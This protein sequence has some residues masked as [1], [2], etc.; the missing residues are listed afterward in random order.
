ME[1]SNGVFRSE[2][3]RKV[4]DIIAVKDSEISRLSHKCGDLNAKINQALKEI[5]TDLN[6]LKTLE[7]TQCN[8]R[9]V[10]RTYKHIL[11]R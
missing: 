1:E 11:K 2:I 4:D 3:G 5:E 9:H 7:F 8:M 6:D 10:L